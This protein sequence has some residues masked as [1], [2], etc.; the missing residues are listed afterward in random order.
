MQRDFQAA[1]VRP[2]AVFIALEKRS[3]PLR[4]LSLTIHRNIRRAGKVST[5]LPSAGYAARPID[6]VTNSSWPEKLGLRIVSRMRCATASIML[7]SKHRS[8]ES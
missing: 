8:A 6:A 2:F 7:G 3:T 1:S 4:P 5:S